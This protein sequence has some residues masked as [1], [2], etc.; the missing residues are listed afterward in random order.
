MTFFQEVFN[1]KRDRQC[2]RVFK[3]FSDMLGNRT[4]RQCRSHFQK[5]MLRF[6]T[7]NKACSFY[8]KLLGEKMYEERF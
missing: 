6:K 3:K 7:P 2:G 1:K 4:P 5:M 8:R